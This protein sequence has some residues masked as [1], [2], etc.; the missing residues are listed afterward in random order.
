MKIPERKG[1]K[2][3]GN[4]ALWLANP[5]MLGKGWSIIREVVENC[6]RSETTGYIAFVSVSPDLCSYWHIAGAS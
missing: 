5:V 2:V 6:P 4:G 1:T 3:R